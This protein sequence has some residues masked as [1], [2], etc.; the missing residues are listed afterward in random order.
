MSATADTLDYPI[1]NATAPG[2]NSFSIRQAPVI[3][4]VP[5]AQ[6]AIGTFQTLGAMAACVRGEIAPDFCGYE[7][8]KVRSLAESLITIEACFDYVAHKIAYGAHPIDRQVIQDACRTIQ[9]KTGDCVSKS[10]LLASLLFAAGYPCK[11][12]AQ[13][14]DDEQC[15]SHVYILARDEFGNEVRLD[16]VA[17][18]QPIGYSQPLPDTGFETSWEIF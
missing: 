9:F 3:R 6:G 12:I 11:F 16:P 14:W 10:V 5:L 1:R 18:D 17:S 2:G 8:L 15:Y 13:Y 7:C 4:H